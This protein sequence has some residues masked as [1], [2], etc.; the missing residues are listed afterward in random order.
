MADATELVSKLKVAV[1]KTFDRSM[2]RLRPENNATTSAASNGAREHLKTA[3]PP[4]FVGGEGGK[5]ALRFLLRFAGFDSTT[6]DFV[7]NQRD[8]ANQQRQNV[9]K[10]AKDQDGRQHGIADGPLE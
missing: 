2:N 1:V 8:H 7:G 10:N 5:A 3:R 6:V 9:I 4:K